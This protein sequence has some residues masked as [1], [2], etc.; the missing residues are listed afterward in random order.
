MD[1]HS[2]VGQRVTLSLRARCEKNSRHAGSHSDTVSRYVTGQKVN[3]ILNPPKNRIKD[4]PG[5]L[6]RYY[7]ELASTLTKKE[8]IAFDQSL[9]ANILLELEKD[10]TLVIQHTTYSEGKNIISE[11]RN[12]CSSGFD[13]IPAKFLKPVA[14]EIALPIVHII[15]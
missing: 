6:N 9:I 5:D 15:N 12:D 1:H 13:N 7:T 2:A 11:L 14:E 3:S 8:S 10:N 4:D